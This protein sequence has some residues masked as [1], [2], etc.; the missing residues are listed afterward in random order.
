MNSQ[1]ENSTKDN[2]GDA[3]HALRVLLTGDTANTLG[4]CQGSGYAIN[5]S[6]L[7]RLISLLEHPEPTFRE[8]VLRAL[9]LS[10]TKLRVPLRDPS[11]Q[12][13]IFELLRS[14]LSADERQENRFIAGLV[15]GL[16]V[17]ELNPGSFREYIVADSIATVTELFISSYSKKNVPHAIA[18]TTAAGPFLTLVAHQNGIGSPLIQAFFNEARKVL[19]TVASLNDDILVESK[20]TMH[21][22]LLVAALLKTLRQS[23]DDTY[24][25]RQNIVEP[26]RSLVYQIF[27][28][29]RKNKWVNR[30]MPDFLCTE[31]SWFICRWFHIPSDNFIASIDCSIVRTLARQAHVVKYSGTLS[32]LEEEVKS[33]L[34][35]ARN[36]RHQ[37]TQDSNLEHQIT[38]TRALSERPHS[39]YNNRTWS[40][41]SKGSDNR[42]K[43]TSSSQGGY[44][45]RR[46]HYLHGYSKRSTSF[47]DNNNRSNDYTLHAQFEIESSSS[48]D[49][50]LSL[51]TATNFATSAA[52]GLQEDTQIDANLQDDDA[53]EVD[54]TLPSEFTSG[55][56][57]QIQQNEISFLGSKEEVVLY[58]TNPGT[59]QEFFS[60]QTF[61][62]QHF[63]A[64]PA[65]GVVEAK[66]SCKI[67]LRFVQDLSNSSLA[68]IR[69]AGFLRVRTNAGL[70]GE[71]LSLSAIHGPYLQVQ[72]SRLNF[73][74]VPVQRRSNQALSLP[75]IIRNCSPVPCNCSISLLQEDPVFT[76]RQTQVLILPGTEFWV[77]VF[78]SPREAKG[79][80]DV[81]VVTGT[82][83]E[84][85]QVKVTG[86]GGSPLRLFEDDLAFGLL[87]A[88]S[89]KANASFIPG[90]CGRSA[91][92]SASKALHIEN[93]DP[94]NSLQVRFISNRPEEVSCSP[95]ILQ[96]GERREVEISIRPYFTGEFNAKLN[97]TAP[98]YSAQ[99]VSLSA[100]V[101]Q[102]VSIPLSQSVNF[103]IQS[104]GLESQFELPL[105]NYSESSVELFI[106]GF[107]D[108][109]CSAWYQSPTQE[110]TDLRG[111]A[112]IV[113]HSQEDATVEIKFLSSKPGL[114]RL[115]IRIELVHPHRITYGP[116]FVTIPC[117]GKDIS[118]DTRQLGSKRLTYNRLRS[119]LA[120][121]IS[122]EQPG[123]HEYDENSEDS[124]DENE[125]TGFGHGQ[126]G[127]ANT[128]TDGA[129][130]Y[131]LQLSKSVSY[132][133]GNSSSHERSY[134]SVTLRNTSSISQPYKVLVSSPFVLRQVRLLEGY[135]DPHDSLELIIE[136][137][138]QLED[139]ASV[140]TWGF[141]SVVYEQHGVIH[142][143]CSCLLQGAATAPVSV[144]C[145]ED[146]LVFQS[147]YR[148][149]ADSRLLRISNQTPHLINLSTRIIQN[150]ETSPFLIIDPERIPTDELSLHVH[151]WAQLD[152]CIQF[153][154]HIEGVFAAPVRCTIEYPFTSHEDDTA[155]ADVTPLKV[156]TGMLDASVYSFSSVHISPKVLDFGDISVGSILEQSILLKNSFRYG[157]QLSLSLEDMGPFEIVQGNFK[158]T[159]LLPAPLTNQPSTTANSEQ[160]IPLDFRVNPQAPCRCVRF[161]QIMPATGN[162]V[163]EYLVIRA[164]AGYC[165]LSSNFGDPTQVYLYSESKTQPE[166]SAESGTC[167]DFGTISTAEKKTAQLEFVLVN[168]GSRSVELIDFTTKAPWLKISIQTKPAHALQY[169]SAPGLCPLQLDQMVEDAVIQ[170]LTDKDHEISEGTYRPSRFSDLQLSLTCQSRNVIDWDEIDYQ[171]ST[172]EHTIRREKRSEAFKLLEGLRSNSSAENKTKMRDAETPTS[173]HERAEPASKEELYAK[174][175]KYTSDLLQPD[176][177][178]FYLEP[179]KEVR[180][181]LSIDYEQGSSGH[182]EE[183]LEIHSEEPGAAAPTIHTFRVAAKFQPALSIDISDI[184]FGVVASGSTSAKYITIHNIG[185]ANVQWRS[186]VSFT[187]ARS[188]E[189]KLIEQTAPPQVENNAE[190]SRISNGF[191]QKLEQTTEYGDIVDNKF[192]SLTPSECTIEPG[193]S[194][195]IKVIFQPNETV[196]ERALTASVGF[197]S[198]IDGARESKF[199]WH[200]QQVTLYG[201]TGAAF[202]S[203]SCGNA[204]NMESV[205]EKDDGSF[206]LDFGCIPIGNRKLV[207]LQL[208]NKGNLA[209]EFVIDRNSSQE[210][211]RGSQF[212]S[213]FNFVPLMG[214]ILP[215]KTQ[216]ISIAYVAAE[217]GASYSELKILWSTLND[218]MRDN[219]DTV[220][221]TIPVACRG[222]AGVPQLHVRQSCVDFDQ[223]ILNVSNTSLLQIFNYGA[224]ECFVTFDMPCSSLTVEHGPDGIRVPSRGNIWVPI[225]FR[226]SSLDRLDDTIVVKMAQDPS[227]RYEV[228]VCGYVGIPELSVT[229]EQALNDLDFDVALVKQTHNRSFTVTNIGDVSL[230]FHCVFMRPTKEAT[231]REEAKQVRDSYAM[232]QHRSSA[233]PGA[234]K[235][236]NQA[237]QT[238]LDV[239]SFPKDFEEFT[240]EYLT[241]E[242][243]DGNFATGVMIHFTVSFEP[244]ERERETRALFVIQ[245]RFESIPAEI[246]G[247]GGD[248]LLELD[249]P[250]RTIDFGLC[251]ANQEY[252]QVIHAMNP[253]NV[254]YDFSVEPDPSDLTVRSI[255]LQYAHNTEN[256]NRRR[257]S[258]TSGAGKSRINRRRSSSSTTSML[259]EHFTRAL[260]RL[261][262]SIETRGTCE[263][264]GRTPISFKFKSPENSPE[265]GVGNQRVLSA[266][267]FLRHATGYEQLTLRAKEG[268][269]SLELY[270]N[271]Q[272]P[273]LESAVD[274]GVRAVRQSHRRTILLYN[275]GKIPALFYVQSKVPREYCIVPRDGKVEP[276]EYLP[277]QIAFEPSHSDHI[278]G[279]FTVVY[280][281]VKRL[282]IN[283]AGLGGQG[284]LEPEFLS[285]RDR[286]MQGLDFQLVST[287]VL[288]EKRVLFHNSGQ[289]PL[290][291]VC[292][293]TSPYYTIGH[294]RIN[295]IQS[296]TPGYSAKF[297]LS[298]G[299][300]ERVEDQGSA[301]M[302]VAR[303]QRNPSNQSHKK[304]ANLEQKQLAPFRA[305]VIRR[306]PK[307]NSNAGLTRQQSKIAI[308]MYSSAGNEKNGDTVVE[309][310]LY[311]GHFVVLRVRLCAEREI[312]YSGLLK[313]RSE[314]DSLTV[315]LRARGGG[316]KLGHVGDLNFGNIAC[317]H[318]YT[319]SIA[320]TNSGSIPTSVQ[321]YWKMKAGSRDAYELARLGV[322][323]ATILLKGTTTRLGQ[324]RLWH[325]AIENV[326]LLVRDARK[327]NNFRPLTSAQRNVIWDLDQHHEMF[328]DLPDIGRTRSSLVSAGSF[329][330]RKLRLTNSASTGL[331]DALQ[332]LCSRG[333]AVGSRMEHI[334]ERFH[335]YQ[336]V[337]LSK[338]KNEAQDLSEAFRSK[339][340]DA[341]RDAK[342]LQEF[343]NSSTPGDTKQSNNAE[344]EDPQQL[345]ERELEE[346]KFSLAHLQVCPKQGTL[347]E[348]MSME[349]NVSLNTSIEGYLDAILVV[350]SMLPGVEP[351]EIPVRA[352]AQEV[353]IIVDDLTTINFGRQALG[354]TKVI[355][356]TFENRGTMA[357]EFRIRNGNDDLVVEPNEGVLNPG[358]LVLIEFVYSPSSEGLCVHPIL[359]ETNCTAPIVF[360][361]YAGGGYPQL[362]LDHYE[363]F[364]FGRCMVGKTIPK[365]LR[366]GNSGN[367]VLTIKALTFKNSRHSHSVFRKGESWPHSLD[368]GEPLRIAPSDNFYVPLVFHPH[369]ESH[370]VDTFTIHTST[371][372]YTLDLT[373]SGREAV[374][375]LS[376]QRVDF[377]DCI[378]GNA[379][380][381]SFEVSNAGDLTYP[382]EVSLI[383][384]EGNEPKA[385][386]WTVLN[387][388]KVEPQSLSISPF[389]KRVITVTYVPSKA[390]EETTDNVRIALSSIYSNFDLPLRLI[391]GTAYL[392]VYP[393]SFNFGHF[394]AT[395]PAKATVTF[396]NTGTMTF[397][398]RLRRV[399]PQ[400]AFPFKLSRW[401]ARLPPK[402]SIEIIATFSGPVQSEVQEQL[403]ENFLGEFCEDLFV[404][405]DLVGSTSIIQMEGKCDASTLRP[406][407]FAQVRM[408]P[409]A[410]GDLITKCV[411]IRNYGGYPAELNLAPSFPLKLTPKTITIPGYGEGT[412][413]IS[414]KP[415]GSYELRGSIK[416]RS[417]VGT[418]DIQ[419]SG[420]GVY[421][422]FRVLGD[423]IN[424]GVC[425]PGTK[426]Q[427]SFKICNTG[428]IDLDWSIPAV[429]PGFEVT[430]DS[431][432]LEPRQSQDV[433]V[434]FKASDVGRFPGD[435]I[436]ESRGRYKI[437]NVLGIGGTYRVDISPLS[438]EVNFGATPC[439]SYCFQE[440]RLINSGSV[441]VFLSFDIIKTCLSQARIKVLVDDTTELKPGTV[442]QIRIGVHPGMVPSNYSFEVKI[443]TLEETRSIVVFGRGHVIAL[444]SD[445]QTILQQETLACTFLEEPVVPAFK[446]HFL[447]SNSIDSDVAHIVAPIQVDDRARLSD[448]RIQNLEMID[449]L[450]CSSLNTILAPPPPHLLN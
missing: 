148:G 173:I 340:D 275:A 200:S 308:D 358:D 402:E 269:A 355:A 76:I 335:K 38:S 179:G 415:M 251:E 10:A 426:Y 387:D 166:R 249:T 3:E 371:G 99:Y 165:N 18:A 445:S 208:H 377:V 153:Q 198:C 301:P 159:V 439:G 284:V 207:E 359:F 84:V 424:F 192:F 130:A 397:S 181:I 334:L 112:T 161:C 136:I 85:H 261:G 157:V 83:S 80:Q 13:R 270:D 171:I 409:C 313:I 90:I 133:F 403:L 107:E 101:G 237:K 231:S 374:L 363:I 91:L 62:S 82:G 81:L 206:L 366:V 45:P 140:P 422:Q 110:A 2:L 232:G 230:E 293:S 94:E 15:L 362:D 147:L 428:K 197:E 6:M 361:V 411:T 135:V 322:L 21:H 440:I 290:K 259:P 305:S 277:L 229:P 211:S 273:Y 266:K 444:S 281:S 410:V 369:S 346:S 328:P 183:N 349:V 329:A 55:L 22:P 234:R 72:D 115:P 70:P 288:M 20:W 378:V 283:V 375:S 74:Y 123:S 420:L 398:F 214:S 427:R 356:R 437:L 97:V 443:R 390:M 368:S 221:H 381:T 31:A 235:S 309:C 325:W 436:V 385:H 267:V 382:L 172:V 264:Y 314:F 98:G 447:A 399:D 73:G 339:L 238:W 54:M 432:N 222:S 32:K 311:P 243:M 164:R 215:N 30:K 216:N 299:E 353:R 43:V 17:P 412:F 93:L 120:V 89:S 223:A 163:P 341:D 396:E 122:H 210:E 143:Y 118:G 37:I 50:K 190:E 276:G 204:G 404:E 19:V 156:F 199:E 36:R 87:H 248:P 169:P 289:V 450:S 376:V 316:V 203:I 142:Q 343:I 1:T 286:N 127:S 224:A 338:Q 433:N 114:Y 391:A 280:N 256:E 152:L 170:A 274:F 365:R 254:P 360:D 95:V 233:K 119:L 128:G 347:S 294:I 117:I 421:P 352:E 253:G 103:P 195:R 5:S 418:F 370:F 431:G 258:I 66:A 176:K 51:Y 61:P 24:E 268:F 113:L 252:V 7:S 162:A 245:N 184:Q 191:S 393:P 300:A 106:T 182:L 351:Y 296:A 59:T 189:T 279:V 419:V 321:L 11:L 429:A 71:R 317:D 134:G 68:S 64:T 302:V 430:P 34:E 96:P 320:L 29:K 124:E 406:S 218:S 49:S 185:V 394:Q 319:K 209:A 260:G 287:H 131:C 331:S 448:L 423:T 212:L 129:E 144:R 58:L 151:P 26:L 241:V 141:L 350:G 53:E 373:G 177:L 400:K 324:L 145:P 104:T 298:S 79:Y 285:Q 46:Y 239:F 242:P 435:F 217:Q 272:T 342:V 345:L 155:N 4:A 236:F 48:S 105:K 244:L 126:T 336:E 27:V 392:N 292:E 57:F 364:D 255:M 23:L 125:E 337:Q 44:I 425:S 262:F 42:G 9:S 438:G 312:S 86:H 196:L 386:K 65:Y 40:N 205:T 202:I 180:I 75:V 102:L 333:D 282:T 263:A 138:P 158:T 132:I 310:A 327:M 304:S 228:D 220:L 8:L 434:F 318:T 446:K 344:F 323:T 442:K 201:A 246:R 154:S 271:D 121:S 297:A 88:E 330:K 167:V 278:E 257:G 188:F 47:S 367:A 389:E 28:V 108:S 39:V 315:P 194:Q 401:E 332:D 384:S 372:S 247:V 33:L 291:L 92:A 295:D 35:H 14:I 77:D 175:R 449:L 25:T 150:A 226:P 303:K 213:S 357:A 408:G 168:S 417:N 16:T 78:F 149:E 160:R 178:P 307:Q 41:I 174:I 219:I 354:E 380:K 265:A 405:T 413:A 407:E 67:L 227:V 116:W 416:L 193:R 137:D 326:L 388:L 139:T 379:Y 348:R 12:T 63:L 414:W 60:L 250:L 56:T 306:P 395:K 69:I 441:T 109:P 100:F 187:R 225:I 146:G 111:G 186:H 240:P 383:C 52:I